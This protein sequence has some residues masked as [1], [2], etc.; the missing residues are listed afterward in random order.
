[1][2]TLGQIK[3]TI[4]K[5][6]A[7]G[8]ET[9]FKFL[10]HLLDRESLLYTVFDDLRKRYESAGIDLARGV[11][12]T[13]KKK[14]IED[15]VRYGLIF[16]VVEKLIAE[17]II[18][19][20]RPADDARSS[21]RTVPPFDRKFPRYKLDVLRLDRND[22]AA[23]FKQRFK[24]LEK[25]KTQHYFVYG[26]NNQQ[27]DRFVERM[28][29]ELESSSHLLDYQPE[30]DKHIF[31]HNL[32]LAGNLHVSKC[33]F[34]EYFEERFGGSVSCLLELEKIFNPNDRYPFVVTVLNLYVD[35]WQPYTPDFFKWFLDDFCQTDPA[36]P[37]HFLF[38]F[39]L[40]K[41][42]TEHPAP[43]KSTQQKQVE[44]FMNS[45]G[46]R[47]N[48][49]VFPELRPISVNDLEK[50]LQAF[51]SNTY[52]ITQLR[53]EILSPEKYGDQLDLALVEYQ[54]MDF[55]RQKQSSLTL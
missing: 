4:K 23:I 22:V 20:R 26:D 7:E 52:A 2:E 41:G 35:E 11:I 30:G 34:L 9:G 5:A 53:K 40:Q 8:L 6:I 47:S 46:G 50:W 1:M 16:V 42:A 33:Y 28:I 44:V 15:Q 12:D 24:M 13:E 32:K 48:C 38:F 31:I 19:S 45:L 54:L 37:A 43:E 55:I 14:E 10:E 27:P 51:I 18:A 21:H 25:E 29:F 36:N 49:T 17:D 39:I 3:E